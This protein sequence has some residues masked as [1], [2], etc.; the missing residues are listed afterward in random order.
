[1][2]S[3]SK[4]SP[5]LSA[6]LSAL[7]SYYQKQKNIWDIGCDHGLLGLFFS[8]EEEVERIHLVDPSAAVIKELQ[9]K[10]K[11]SYITKG[12]IL[13][14][15][16]HGQQLS[17]ETTSN[18][19]FIAGMGGKEIG[20]III[21]LL[22]SLDA[23][24]SVVISPHRKILELRALLRELP[25]ALVQEELIFEDGQFYQILCL[26]KGEGP[27]VHPYGRDIWKK[28]VGKHYRD[29][30]MKYFGVHEDLASKGYMEYLAD[31]KLLKST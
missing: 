13:I 22:P 31:P 2:M 12:E 5:F 3:S 28:E 8:N 14:H 16:Q 27:R 21:H 19:I 1:M 23:T 24:S 26:R 30:Q 15:H 25:L 7:R 4:V 9:N 18:C 11:D 6:R 17:I 20:E 29:H 10:L